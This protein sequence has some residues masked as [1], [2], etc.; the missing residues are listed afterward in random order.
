MQNWKVSKAENGEIEWWNK[1]KLV[2][3]RLIHLKGFEN[4]WMIISNVILLPLQK[5]LIPPIFLKKK[6]EALKIVTNH[7][8]ET[9][10]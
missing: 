4:K 3:I 7:M 5:L 1:R 2:S 6:R 9:Q 10:E 8:R